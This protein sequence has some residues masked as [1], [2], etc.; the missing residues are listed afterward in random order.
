MSEYSKEEIKNAATLLA[1][2]IRAAREKAKVTPA[3]ADIVY[4]S[5]AANLCNVGITGNQVHNMLILQKI[6]DA[7]DK[8]VD[9]LDKY[10]W[11]FLVLGIC[12]AA[13][14]VGAYAFTNLIG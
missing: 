14:I 4:L 12:F 8:M 11:L 10:G 1:K 2:N 13:A 6:A 7:Y 5:D 9:I 3:H